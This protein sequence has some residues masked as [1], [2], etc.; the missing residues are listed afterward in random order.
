M[1]R[2]IVIHQKILR[3][4]VFCI[5]VKNVA[6]VLIKMRT[7]L[8][9]RELKKNPQEAFLPSEAKTEAA[10]LS[11]RSETSS[12]VPHPRRA[13][14]AGTSTAFPGSG[15]QVLGSPFSSAPKLQL[16]TLF[17]A[18]PFLSPSPFS[19]QEIWGRLGWAQLVS[20]LFPCYSLPPSLCS[21]GE[22]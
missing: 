16:V 9:I 7:L 14:A 19:G 6:S 22:G 15:S 18:T 13:R 4:R 17:Q 21:L 8:N 1:L 20:V 12:D 10:S 5:C 3:E 2:P 11:P